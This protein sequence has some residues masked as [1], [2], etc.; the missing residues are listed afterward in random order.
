MHSGRRDRKDTDRAFRKSYDGIPSHLSDNDGVVE[1]CLNSIVAT[2]HH[3]HYFHSVGCGTC[4]PFGKGAPAWSS[5]LDL[6]D[7]GSAVPQ[8]Y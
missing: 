7:S 6:V 2:V 1:L 4:L 8:K 3:I 5:R